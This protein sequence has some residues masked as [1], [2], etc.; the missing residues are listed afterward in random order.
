M[1]QF[2]PAQTRPGR[3]SLAVEDPYAVSS[4]YQDVVGLDQFGY[5]ESSATLG[6]GETPL[7]ELTDGSDLA[8]RTDAQAGLYHVA[9]RYPSQEA[10][11]AALHRVESL[12]RLDGATDHGVTH[13]LYLTDPAG[14]GVELFVDQPR[15]DWPRDEA[16]EVTM[17]TQPLDLDALRAAGEPETDAPAGTTIGHFH[18]E[19]TD[20]AGATTFYRDG[21]GLDITRE[22]GDMARFLAVGDSHHQLG[23]TTYQDRTEP[24]TGRG[25]DWIEFLTP[26]EA[27]LDA[28]RERFEAIGS[29][30]ENRENGIAVTDPD[31]IGVRLSLVDQ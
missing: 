17:Q 8:P 14:N 5:T 25:L 10:L 18:L 4:F 16:D 23:I 13:S 21:L 1:T 19:V 2:L 30:V 27:A 6:A 9:F 24:A 28:A 12:Y 7:V 15:A 20:L 29:A 31:G 26:S 3:L 22:I 11:G